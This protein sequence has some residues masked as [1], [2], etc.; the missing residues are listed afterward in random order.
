MTFL[1]FKSSDVLIM[2]INVEMQTIG[3]FTFKNMIN[4]YSVELE[5]SFITSGPG[6]NQ[7]FDFAPSY[8]SEQ[9]C[10]LIRLR[11]VFHCRFKNYLGP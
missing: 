5:K 1:A 4:S 3:I 6:Q 10:D 11:R 9:S 2:L 7:Q 8:D